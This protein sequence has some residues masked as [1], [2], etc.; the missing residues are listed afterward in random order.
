MGRQLG[1]I[2]RI[3]FLLLYF[4]LLFLF[5][6]VFALYGAGEIVH[7]VVLVAL[8]QGL[9]VCRID[10]VVD[11]AVVVR[12]GLILRREPPLAI[13]NK[14]IPNINHTNTDGPA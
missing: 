4:A 11:V 8:D 14:L 7:V 10:V 6:G 2:L 12:H 13:H 3:L 1:R 5:F 9:E